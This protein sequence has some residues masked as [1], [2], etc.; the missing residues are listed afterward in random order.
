MTRIKTYKELVRLKSFEER[1]DY[2]RLDGYVGEM[3]FNGHRYLNQLLYRCP[4]WKAIRREVII[5]DGGCDLAMEDRVITGRLL[6][7]HMNPITAADIVERADCVFDL[8][9]LICV[10]HNTHNAIHYG[11]ESLI[12]KGP[13]VRTKHDTCPWR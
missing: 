8:E 9:N 7:H 12:V 10:S 2:L 1:F 5:R 13:V 6:V 3:T 4:E 11:D